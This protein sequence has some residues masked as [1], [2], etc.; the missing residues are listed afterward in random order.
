MQ[1][2]LKWRTFLVHSTHFQVVRMDAL[3]VSLVVVLC[4]RQT[5]CAVTFLKMQKYSK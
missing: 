2:D 4:A 1:I 5:L 3:T